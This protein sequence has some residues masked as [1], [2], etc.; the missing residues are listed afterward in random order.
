V[1]KKDDKVVNL[2]DV[3]KSWKHQQDKTKKGSFFA[4]IDKGNS[5]FNMAS[6]PTWE[7]GGTQPDKKFAASNK[8][9]CW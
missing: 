5:D 3:Q 6:I 9:S 1:E 8:E 7:E 4:N 2:S